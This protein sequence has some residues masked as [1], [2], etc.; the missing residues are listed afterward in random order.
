MFSTN[1][2]P[3]I[4]KLNEGH[5]RQ[6]PPGLADA[7]LG[8]G[9]FQFGEHHF[10]EAA[11]ARTHGDVHPLDLGPAV[12]EPAPAAGGDGYAVQQSDE[13]QPFRRGELGRI[14]RRSVRAAVSLDVL[15]L[16]LGDHPGDVRVVVATRLDHE[17]H[18]SQPTNAL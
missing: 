17:L 9:A 13:E 14:D 16:D 6:S 12:R 4:V 2:V 3:Y 11:S 10:R 5:S 1:N 18:A 15:S 8:G 7:G